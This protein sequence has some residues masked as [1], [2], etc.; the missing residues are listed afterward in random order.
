METTAFAQSLTA[1]G[2][3]P[4]L[5][6]EPV[7]ALAPQVETTIQANLSQQIVAGLLALDECCIAVL[8][9]LEQQ[10]L[11]LGILT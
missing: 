7:E 10:L 1:D 3:P 9:G 4:T 11:S 5:V 2:K 6:V 8:I